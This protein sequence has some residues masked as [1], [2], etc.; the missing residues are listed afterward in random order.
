MFKKNLLHYVSY[1][2][3]MAA[4]AAGTMA[5]PPAEKISSPITREQSDKIK[6][7]L[8]HVEGT[9]EDKADLKKMLDTL[10]RTQIGRDILSQVPKDIHYGVE[11][12]DPW[13]QSCLGYYSRDTKKIVLN[14][15]ELHEKKHFPIVLAHEMRHAVQDQEKLLEY[16]FIN[17]KDEAAVAKLC[18]LET[19][20]YDVLLES[21]LL[22]LLE[23]QNKTASAPTMYYTAL[24]AQGKK[25]GLSDKDAAQK[26]KD[27][28]IQSSWL[29]GGGKTNQTIHLPLLQK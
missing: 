17:Q 1:T 11:E 3:L 20:V 14:R 21:Q 23:N 7:I 6:H 19:R 13:N 26:A 4:T 25:S 9:E 28:L 8:T 10:N 29:G 16:D 24:Y 22:A 15:L 5:M 12:M 27:A 18:E 2:V